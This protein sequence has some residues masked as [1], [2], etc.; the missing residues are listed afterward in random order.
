VD[1]D[2]AAVF[3]IAASIDPKVAMPKHGDRRAALTALIGAAFPVMGPRILGDSSLLDPCLEPGW[4]D[5]IH[6]RDYRRRLQEMAGRVAPE[7]IPAELRRF[8]NRHRLRIALREV[9][10]AASGGVPIDVS[11]RE[12]SDLAAA[13][14]DFALDAAMA[15]VRPRFGLPRREDGSPSS[16][17]VMGMGK[18]GGCELNAGSDVD[19]ICAYD[20]DDGSAD[21]PE[22]ISLHEYWT[23]VVRGMVP[24]LEQVTAEGFV[25]RVDLRL[26][27]EGSSGPLVNSLPAMLRYYETWGRLWERAVWTRARPVAG[28]LALGWTLIRELEP[29]VYR[30]SVDPRIADAMGR[31]VAQA[32]A[33]AGAGVD[34]DLKLG[35]GGIRDLETFVQT[36]QLVWGGKHRALRVRPTLEALDRLR[37]HGFVTEREAIDLGE[38][39]AM[40]RSAEHL[41]QNATGRQTHRVPRDP[42]ALDR[43]ARCLGFLSA[44]SCERRLAVVRDRVRSC[45]AAL[46]TNGH[47]SGRWTT[48]FAALDRGDPPSV[49]GQ[50]QDHL[51]GMATEALARDILLLA[52]GPDSVLGPVTRDQAQEHTEA[53]LDALIESADP[54]Q[55]ARCLCA[56]SSHRSFRS[57]YATAVRQPPALLRRFVTALGGSAFLGDMISRQPELAEHAL[58]SRGIPSVEAADAAVH[59]EVGQLGQ[60]DRLDPELVAG[61]IRRAKLRVTLEVVLADMAA[62]V[63]VVQVTR[64]LS[65]LADA[66]VQA[67]LR[68]SC[69]ESDE[70]QGLCALSVGK[71]GGAE[72]GYGSDLDLLFVFEPRPGHEEADEMGRRARHAQRTIRVLSGVHAEGP[73]YELDTRLRP[74]GSQGVLVTSRRAFVKYHGLT[75]DAVM[76]VRAA[77]WERQT[78]LRAR[79]SAGDKAL[80]DRVLSLARQAAYESGAPDVEEIDRLRTRLER[81]IGRERGGRF[82]IKLGRG[83]LLDIEFAVQMLQMRYGTDPSVRTSNTLEAIDALERSGALEAGDAATLREG[84]RFLRTLEQRL[85]V[86]HNTSLHLIEARAPGL[87]PLARRMGITAAPGR[88]APELLLDRHAQIT[89]AVRSAYE[90]IMRTPA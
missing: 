68:V 29:F 2:V 84:Y 72:L 49:I 18:L 67:A 5:P 79:V 33:E 64:V 83:G 63:D 54:E 44:Q 89:N 60:D 41:V 90:R 8:A 10:P 73:G 80:G 62:E 87:L 40:L 17:V 45:A 16:I 59:R 7:V 30:R 22:A 6:A 36:L 51:Q 58:F 14:I 48:L 38:A 4:E 37:T 25:W 77:P 19:L 24:L 82:D 26:R 55:A 21:G 69:G 86:V 23:R 81:E 15:E 76:G 56:W 34:Q 74:S 27:P 3:E 53:V 61:A 9:L 35:A 52:S 88:G 57:V 13:T 78:L 31:L 50:L 71:L 11:A 42:E 66:C 46:R 32:R 47:R 70:V 39:Y 75:D 85:H 43:L 65:S 1:P 20:T 12:L 28:D